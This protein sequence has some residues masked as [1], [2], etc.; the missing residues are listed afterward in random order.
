MEENIT[1]NKIKRVA[2]F[3]GSNL[4]KDDKY[5]SAAKDLGKLLV[6]EGIELIYGGGRIGLMGVI[7]DSVLQAGGNVIGVMPE[8][9]VKREALHPGVLDLRVV[10]TMHS[11]KAMMADLADAFISIPGGFGTLDELIEIVTWN[12]L[13]VIKKPVGL[14]NVNNYFDLLLDF[15]AKAAEEGFLRMDNQSEIF[16][17]KDIFKL[18]NILKDNFEANTIERLELV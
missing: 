5:K 15:I 6:K 8:F 12:Q 9:L 16:I 10:D 1:I 14:L 3:C 13:G 11:R 17:Q 7:A 18:L 4:G 2:V